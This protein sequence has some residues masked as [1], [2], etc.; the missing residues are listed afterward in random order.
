MD[1]VSNCSVCWVGACL[2]ILLLLFTDEG[3]NGFSRARASF[4]RILFWISYHF[5]VG[6]LFPL[7][8]FCFTFQVSFVSLS[9]LLSSL[10]SLPLAHFCWLSFRFSKLLSLHFSWVSFHFSMLPFHFSWLS[11][12]SSFFLVGFRLICVGFRFALVSLYFRFTLV[13]FQLAFA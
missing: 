6:F 4:W 3:S 5:L 2:L 1:D 8:G 13:S 10:F 9:S 12:R 7:V 11:L